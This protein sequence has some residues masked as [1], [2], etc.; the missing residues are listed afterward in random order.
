M[1][2]ITVTAPVPVNSLKASRW[3]KVN[4][5]TLHQP[6]R[7]R[8]DKCLSKDPCKNKNKTYL[9]GYVKVGM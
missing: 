9:P 7:L 4:C 5:S 2:L 1:D 8:K 3:E 6:L